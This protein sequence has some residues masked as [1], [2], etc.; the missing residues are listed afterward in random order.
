MTHY[1][2]C[3]IFVL[4]IVVRRISGEQPP[5]EGGL[6]IR[7][8]DDDHNNSGKHISQVFFELLFSCS[9]RAMCIPCVYHVYTM[10][11]SLLVY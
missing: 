10:C 9:A 4:C 2:S 7:N 5:D 1:F 11:E 8:G 3:V 6:T